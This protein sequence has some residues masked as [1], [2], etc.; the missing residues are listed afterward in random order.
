MRSPPSH[1]AGDDATRAPRRVYKRQMSVTR[2]RTRVISPRSHDSKGST[3]ATSSS[4][5]HRVDVLAM[6]DIAVAAASCEQAS[7]PADL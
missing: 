7:R 2:S 1:V 5:D 3:R 6:H 4:G